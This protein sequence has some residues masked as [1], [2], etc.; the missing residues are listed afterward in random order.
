MGDDI[1]WWHKFNDEDL[2]GLIVLAI[3]MIV[4]VFDFCALLRL[5][6]G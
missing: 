2:K 1:V 6:R 3:G 4:I 5:R